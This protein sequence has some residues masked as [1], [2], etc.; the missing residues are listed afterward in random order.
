MVM[1]HQVGSMAMMSRDLGGVV[2][3]DL[4]VYGT[5]NV[6]VVDASV[7]P[8]QISGHLT[9]VIY[10]IAEKAADAIKA[11]QEQEGR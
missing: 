6:R 10:A 11:S 8:T 4:K 7:M 1:N 3:A 5:A 9:A 2:D